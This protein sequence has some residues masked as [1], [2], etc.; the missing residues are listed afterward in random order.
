MGN[1]IAVGDLE[2]YVHFLTRDEGQFAARIKLDDNAVMSLVPGSNSKQLI[3]ETRDGGLYAI[4]VA[5]LNRPVAAPE[6]R[7]EPAKRSQPIE[8]PSE[9]IVPESSPPNTERSIMFQKDPILQ[10]DTTPSQ[11]DSSGPGIKLPSTEP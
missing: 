7:S 6:T 11:P 2:G 9:S 3:A 1:V 8:A 5:E 10:P 4:S